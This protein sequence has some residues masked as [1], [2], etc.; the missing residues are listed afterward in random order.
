MHTSAIESLGN[1]YED[2]SFVIDGTLK[3]LHH[4]QEIINSIR[5]L[6]TS[7]AKA[8]Q[9]MRRSDMWWSGLSSIGEGAM[10]AFGGAGAALG[11]VGNAATSTL[12]AVSGTIASGG[13]EYQHTRSTSEGVTKTKTSITERARALSPQPFSR[14]ARTPTAPPSSPAN[15]SSSLVVKLPPPPQSSS[16]TTLTPVR[17]QSRQ[18]QELNSR[19]LSASSLLTS[20]FT[21]IAAVASAAVGQV[22][23]EEIWDKVEKASSLL[24]SLRGSLFEEL[25]HL[26]SH[27]TKE[28][29]RAMRDF[30][31]RQLQIEKSRLRDMIEILDD[32]RMGTAVSTPTPALGSQI[33]AGSTRD[34]TL[35]WSSRGISRGISRQSSSNALGYMEVDFCRRLRQDSLLAKNTTKRQ[36]RVSFNN[37]KQ[38]RAFSQSVPVCS[39]RA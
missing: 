2:F 10:T 13:T 12:E 34:P 4:P 19:A 22:P 39:F 3:E 25:A 38:T 15:E 36:R 20:P 21:S 18:F 23:L 14:V 29:E 8:E 37:V 7:A 5:Q 31:A 33:L 9:S 28:L 16:T 30:G 11:A 24:N 32:L 17:P 35:G 6:R 27:H 26:Q 1:L